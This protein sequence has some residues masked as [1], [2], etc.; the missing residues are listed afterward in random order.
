MN[1]KWDVN[2]PVQLEN[3]FV[4]G[5]MVSEPQ[6]SW[7]ALLSVLEPLQTRPF[8]PEKTEKTSGWKVVMD[9]LHKRNKKVFFKN[10]K[11]WAWNPFKKTN[12][13]EKKHQNNAKVWKRKK[14]EMSPLPLC[15]G[16]SSHVGHLWGFWSPNPQPPQVQVKVQPSCVQRSR[17][18]DDL[19]LKPTGGVGIA[20]PWVMGVGKFPT[21]V[22]L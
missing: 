9:C 18:Q 20:M 7:I 12:R 14:K 21:W 13:G 22:K 11:L 3:L 6:W 15:F 8:D 19:N 4:C 5:E 10:S 16:V 1:F 17:Y 2:P